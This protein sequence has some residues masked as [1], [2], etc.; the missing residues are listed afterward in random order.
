[1]QEQGRTT[2]ALVGELGSGKSVTA[3]SIVRLS[4]RAARVQ[5]QVLFKGEDSSGSRR[6]TA[7]RDQR[8]PDHH[9]LPGANDLA[10]SLAYDRAADRRDI[11]CAA[12]ARGAKDRGTHRRAFAG[13]RYSRSRRAARRLPA[14]ALRGP[15]PAGDDRHGAHQSAR[16]FYR[17]RADD[18]PRCTRSSP[19]FSSF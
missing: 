5:G 18:R 1:M 12:D 14:S 16:S 13:S 19:R 10:Q 3:L 2:L 8:R 9:G 11:E 7:A 17:R 6:G 4:G 15:A